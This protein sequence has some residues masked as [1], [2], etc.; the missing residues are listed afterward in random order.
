MTLS[1]DYGT[2]YGTIKESSF[3]STNNQLKNGTSI[4]K[5]QY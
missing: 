2:A 1:N 3:L 4:R 5:I